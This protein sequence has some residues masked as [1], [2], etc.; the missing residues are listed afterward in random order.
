MVL[1]PILVLGLLW[2]TNV[3][4]R[5][6]P[7]RQKVWELIDPK[8]SAA[9]MYRNRLPTFVLVNGAMV[10]GG[11]NPNAHPVQ[12]LIHIVPLGII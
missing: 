4:M 8:G 10:Q 11:I 1:A 3:W 9:T 6:N 2:G 12:L 7:V 5:S